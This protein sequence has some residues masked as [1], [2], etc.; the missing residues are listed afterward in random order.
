MITTLETPVLVAIALAALSAVLAIICRVQMS[1][2][3]R[4]QAI[5][6]QLAS[7]NEI[8]SASYVSDGIHARAYTAGTIRAS[9]PNP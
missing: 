8:A 3:L 9:T 1:R 4:L 2:L 7:Q 6:E 5:L